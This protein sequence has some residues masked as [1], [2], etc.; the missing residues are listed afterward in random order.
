MNYPNQSV[1][2][3][4][5]LPQNVYQQ[6]KETAAHEQQHLEAFLSQL[7]VDGLKSHTIGKLWETVSEQYRDRLS[8]AG[9]LAQSTDEVLQTLRNIREQVAD[10]F[11][12]G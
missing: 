1:S 3:T 6:A 8:Q 2:V 9:T 11:Y 5:M 7:I 10:E 4:V 12:S